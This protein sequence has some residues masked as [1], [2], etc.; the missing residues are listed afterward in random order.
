VD[1]A[2][3][4]HVAHARRGAFA[5]WSATR[6]L[7]GAIGAGS[8]GVGSFQYG[9]PQRAARRFAIRL[10][11]DPTSTIMMRGAGARDC[12]TGIALLYSAAYGGDYRPWLAMRAA[13]DAADGIAGALTLRAGTR[14]ASQART[15]RLALLLSCVEWLLWRSS[16]GDRACV[17]QTGRR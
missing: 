13:V 3:G 12:L 10:G 4:A 9:V 5:G 1:L 16:R 7:A 11:A 6:V 15:M 2:S 14:C 8:V 17:P